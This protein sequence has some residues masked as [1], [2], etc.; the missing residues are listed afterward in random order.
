MLGAIIF[1]G[2]GF[3]NFP[4]VGDDKTAT[5]LFRQQKIMTPITG[6]PYSLKLAKIVLKSVFLNKINTQSVVICDSLHF[7]YQKFYDPPIFLS[8][9]L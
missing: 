3:P 8:K 7:G 6:T 4:K 5:P 1:F 2:R 9:N